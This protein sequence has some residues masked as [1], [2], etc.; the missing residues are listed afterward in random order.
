M[1][2]RWRA[3][4]WNIRPLILDQRRPR[5]STSTSPLGVT[6]NSGT[7]GAPQRGIRGSVAGIS[8]ITDEALRPIMVRNATAI[9]IGISHAGGWINQTLIIERRHLPLTTAHLIQLRRTNC[10]NRSSRPLNIETR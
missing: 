3:I 8:I 2:S 10:P 6:T 5:N 7:D 1:K 9:G 4:P